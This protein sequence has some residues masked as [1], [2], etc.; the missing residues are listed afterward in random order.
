M[1]NN[2][3]KNNLVSELTTLF[4]I[5]PI[6]RLNFDIFQVVNFNSYLSDL[7]N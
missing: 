6:A 4:L 1:K 3:H 2:A 5:D 7:A